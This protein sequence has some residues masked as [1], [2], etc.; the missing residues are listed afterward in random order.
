MSG[1]IG[2]A[3]V[4]QATQT[5]EAFTATSGQTTFNTGGYTA[6]FIDVY[7]NG[8]KLAAADYT[9]TNGSD[10]VL[11]TGA[12]TGDILETV[13]YTAFTVADQDFT[14]TTTTEDLTVTG[15]FTSQGIDDNAT[16]TAMT[17][18]SSGNLLVG[19]TELLPADNSIEGMT[20]RNGL[21]LQ[22]FRDA[23]APVV[24]GRGSSD[25][26][27]AVFSKDGTTVG[28][29]GTFGGRI[30]F[31]DSPS[32]VTIDDAA[33]TFR[34]IN[35]SN[36]G[37]R[38]GATDLGDASNRWK[39]LYLSGGVY[40]GGTGSANKLDDYEEGTW[41][42]TIISDN[43]TATLTG[44]GSYVKIGAMVHI[45]FSAYHVD[46]SAL[47]NG[48]IRLGGLPFST[49]GEQAFPIMIDTSDNSSQVWVWLG[50]SASAGYMKQSEFNNAL[51]GAELSDTNDI[52]LSA[53]YR[54][55]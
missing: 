3:P 19:S 35:A 31:A 55:S 14:G 52:Y 9:A 53:T 33:N 46:L 39:N 12:A 20:Y 50:N 25:G 15:A 42:P 21:S 22:V 5:R 18:D 51:T 1:Y 30:V 17:L 47:T 49:S 44:A 6:G 36:G 37:A 24:F 34:T 8:V 11:A 41:T 2:P 28:S 43:A 38:D 32:G 23:G 10:V 29:I 13:A 7:L 48:S 40:L 4:P 26:D 27:V 54:T 16:S 45:R